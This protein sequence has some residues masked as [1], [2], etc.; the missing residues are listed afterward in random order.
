[1]KKKRVSVFLSTLLVASALLGACS[2]NTSSPDTGS[3]GGKENL[4]SQGN[5]EQVVLSMHSWRVEDGDGYK[6]IIKE[7]EQTNPGVKIEFKAFKSTEYNTILNTALQGDSGPDIMQLRPYQA[8]MSLADSGYL[9]PL[10]SVPGINHFA[11]DVLKAAT[12]KD[13]KVYG[14]PLSL[15]STQI[16]YNK[17]MFVD[18][19][20]QEPK[21]WDELLQTAKA[22]KDKGVTPFAFGAKEAWLL[23]LSHGVI[24][25]AEYGGNEFVDKVQKGE[26]N[27]LSP[28]FKKSIE[29]MKELAPY[30]PDNFVGL[31]QNDT[32]AL[33]ATEKA[34]MYIHGSFDLDPMHKLNPNL[35]VDFF[36]LQ[37]QDGNPLITTWVDGS[38]GVNAKSP[39][40]EAALKFMEFMATQKFGEM[41]ANEFKRISAVPGVKVDDPLVN[42]MA[43]RT[44]KNA[45]PYLILVYFGEGNPT[46]KAELENSLQG[47][48]LD[49]MTPDQVAETVQKSAESWFAPFKK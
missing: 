11:P 42:K 25:P 22:L 20:I 4:G 7:F 5:Q 29:Q 13:G 49:K 15:N 34:A 31:D 32:R 8:G 45:T 44:E 24:A 23:S 33:F 39:H 43:E 46:T 2:S 10:D 16:Y 26:A 41:F 6:K 35:D 1:M 48:Y 27:F 18:Q 37:G 19:G 14:V 30:F 17:K 38:W 40:K 36:T 9:E 12:A 28:E 21:T 47:M 3:Q